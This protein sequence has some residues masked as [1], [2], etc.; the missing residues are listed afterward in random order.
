MVI[1][2]HYFGPEAKLNIMAA[3]VCGRAGCSLHGRQEAEKEETGEQAGITFKGM[4]Q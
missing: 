3:R 1:W 2:L 4:P